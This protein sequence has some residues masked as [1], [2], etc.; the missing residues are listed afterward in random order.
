MAERAGIFIHPSAYVDDRAE[1]GVGTKIWINVQVRENA[2]IGVNCVLSKDVYI[3][4]AVVIGDECKVQNGVSIY[5]GVT[6]G[7]RVFVGPNACFTNDKA[8]RAFSANWQVTPTL[9]ESGASIGANAT[10]ICG[11]RIGSF[12]MVAAGSTVTRDIPAHALVMGT[13]ARQVGWIS[14]AGQRL[15][16]P[17]SGRGEAVCAADGSRYRLE[18]DLLRR[19]E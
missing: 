16:L 2:R 7:D 14:E 8:P 13:P 3:D 17:L 11:T 5:N 12:A 6:I 19:I 9:V 10:I 15:T 18:G 4:H 1:I